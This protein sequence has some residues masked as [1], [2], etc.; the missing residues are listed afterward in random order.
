MRRAIPI[1]LS[2]LVAL[3]VPAVL[4]GNSLWVLA[5]GWYVH[6]EYARPDFPDDRYGFT[7]AE[8]TDLALVGLRSI[9]PLNRDGVD[10][11]REPRLADGSPAFTEREIAHMDD[12]RGLVGKVLLA[13]AIALAVVVAA[14]VALWRLRLKS[15]FR[16]DG[17]VLHLETGSKSVVTHA[18][19]RGG[20]LMLAIAAVLGVLMLVNFDWFFVQYHEALFEGDSWRFRSSDTLLRL[21]PDAFWSDFGAVLAGLTVLQAVLLTG[22]AWRRLRQSR[23]RT[24]EPAPAGDQKAS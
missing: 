21:Y 19:L 24:L 20:V 10:V 14:V 1:V 8:R 16:N 9:Q 7:K 5:N 6:A 18:L 13:H 3:A 11:L 4:L 23:V 17:T 15:P 2:A 22:G 12:V